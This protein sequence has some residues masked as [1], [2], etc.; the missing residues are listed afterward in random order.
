MDCA[1]L[2]P[3]QMAKKSSPVFS[4]GGAGEWSLP[5]VSIRPAFSAAHSASRVPTSRMGGAHLSS[6]PTRSTSSPVQWR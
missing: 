4:S 6:A 1:P 5:T 2:M 3:P